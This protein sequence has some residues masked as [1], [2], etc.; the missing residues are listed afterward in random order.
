[1]ANMAVARRVIGGAPESWRVAGIVSRAPQ[2]PAPGGR[3]RGRWRSPQEASDPD[4]EARRILHATTSWS[5]PETQR[6]V[7]GLVCDP[8]RDRAV[9]RYAVAELALAVSAPAIR[10]TAGREAARVTPRSADGGEAQPAPDGDG[11]AAVR[12]RAARAV[13]ELPNLVPAP[14]EGRAAWGDAAGGEARRVHA[15][16]GVATGDRRRRRAGQR[17]TGGELAVRVVTPAVGDASGGEAARVRGTR[18]EHSEG[19]IACNQCGRQA[20]HGIA[21]AQLAEAGPAPAIRGAGC[22]KPA[23]DRAART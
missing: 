15:R 3:C 17:V 21:G 6:H 8:R 2:P 19:Q 9:H 11:C 23:R 7:L 10:H 5:G 16:V 12:A 20:A 4:T 13:P 18:A 14:A 1:M 22:R